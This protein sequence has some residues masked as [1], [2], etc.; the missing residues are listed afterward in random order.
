MFKRRPAKSML[1]QVRIATPC[2]ADWNRMEGDERVR[3]C[4][5]CKLNV[6]NIS[7]M[8][9]NEA[10]SLIKE[11]EGRLCLKLYRRK[12]GTVIT[13]DCPVALRRLR[14]AYRRCAAAILGMAAWTGIAQP[15]MAQEIQGGISPPVMQHDMGDAAYPLGEA[16]VQPGVTMGSPIPVPATT[17]ETASVPEPQS[18][19]VR[20][21]IL[22]AI[23]A[24]GI[25]ALRFLRK[26]NN[27]WM[28]GA[29]FVAIFAMAGF[30]WSL[31]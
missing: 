16:T 26:R 28:I 20:Y 22:A 4:G 5:Q 27:V 15:G 1:E 24:L 23:A 2:P 31:I 14:R 6:Y 11:N 18:P 13:D 29:T 21:S 17:A 10:E 8:S 25:F 7:A 12:D 9:R 30:V 3:Y 19:W